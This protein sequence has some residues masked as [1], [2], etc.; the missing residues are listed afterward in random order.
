MTG[1]GV[2]GYTEEQGTGSSPLPALGTNGHP[3]SKSIKLPEH[4]KLLFS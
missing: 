3:L 2:G 4:L 1:V